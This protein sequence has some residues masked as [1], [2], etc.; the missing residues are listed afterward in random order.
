MLGKR[1]FL[2]VVA[3]GLLAVLSQAALAYEPVAENDH[4][5]LFLQADN[6][7][8]RIQDKATGY[9]WSSVIEELVYRE[10]NAS[11][12]NFMSTGLALE[13][14]EENRTRAIRTDLLSAKEVDIEIE[15]EAQGFLARISFGQLGFHFQVQVWLEGNEVV[16]Y[17]P[18]DSIEESKGAR[19]SAVYLFPFLGATRQGELPGYLFIPDGVGAVID[20]V[21]NQ[22]KYNTP[23]EERFFGR[24]EG[25]S[26]VT[27]Y[28][29]VQAPYPLTAPVFGLFHDSPDYGP[30]GVFAIVEE[31]QYNAQLVAYPNGVITQYNWITTKFYLRETYSQPTSRTL[32]GVLV[33]EQKRNPEDL[34]VR[35]IFSHGSA[36]N[37]V[38]MAHVYQNYLATSGI[39]SPNEWSRQNIPVRLDILGGEAANGLF[40]KNLVVMTTAAQTLAMVQELK[41]ALGAEMMV[42]YRGWNTGGLSGRS[43]YSIDFERKLGGSNGFRQLIHELENNGV[44]LFFYTDYTKA[45]S[46]SGRFS[47]RS[48]GARRIN[49][50]TIEKPTWKG[51][52]DRYYLLTPER[53]GELIKED[54]KLLERA[55]IQRVA[56][57]S[58]AYTL[59]S[60]ARSDQVTFRR[61]SAELYQQ[62]LGEL[63]RA[64]QSLVLFEPNAYLWG[65]TDAFLDLPL[66][67]S[68][69]AFFRS[70]PFLP[71][72]LRGYLD[73]FAPYTNFFANQN[74]ELLRL[75]EYGA[76][77]SYYL[78]EQPSY[79]LKHTNSNDIFT[80]T[81]LD[82]REVLM[83]QYDLVNSIL[84]Q[85]DGAKILSH[86]ELAK[87]VVAVQYSN[88]KRVIVNYN[89]DDYLWGTTIIPAQ[90]AAVEEVHAL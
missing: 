14:F 8:I 69:Y 60:H 4:L 73:Y 17:V 6:L 19:L 11:W 81:Y 23:Y 37:Y 75:V 46:G 54:L 56:V 49:K 80:S 9:I 13:Y 67:A 78:T 72:T 36:A 42:I 28:E 5:I 74:E 84:R 22:N 63:Q 47:V 45:Y 18:Q 24:N 10:N 62:G 15:P 90:G 31:G 27:T 68:Q 25:L 21:D 51:V 66:Y 76:F 32:G 77:P 83:E 26:S 58:T 52:Y 48:D 88:K 82:W 40:F 59:F 53:T 41:S 65:F 79:K 3:F 44:Q 2:V 61:D 33:Y 29:S 20:F 71:I 39:L 86:D 70:V 55:G 85:V 43:P 57:D 38:G 35:Y 34:K 89:R 50:T 64:L 1:R 12:S 30:Q 16:V 7:A 87:G